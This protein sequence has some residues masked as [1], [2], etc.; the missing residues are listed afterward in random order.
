MNMDDENRIGDDSINTSVDCCNN[1]DLEGN[2]LE[3][4]LDINFSSFSNNLKINDSSIRNK[5]NYMF[6]MKILYLF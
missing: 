3:N 2:D 4:E 5:V 1:S 6:L